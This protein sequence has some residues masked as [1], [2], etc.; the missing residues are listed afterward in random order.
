MKTPEQD[1][2]LSDVLRNESYVAFRAELHQKSLAEFRRQRWVQRRSRFLALAACVPVLLGLY[3]FLTP[4]AVNRSEPQ[5]VVATIRSRPLSKDQIITTARLAGTLVTTI[6]QDLRLT[7]PLATIEV[8]R[9]GIQLESV[10]TISDE[11]LL[12]LFP[13][14]PIALVTRQ[15]GTKMLVFLDGL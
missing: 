4:R 2:L 10:A 1:R 7:L 12:D 3:L 9:T 11:Q 8:V 13:G 14:R 6:P 5:A 15:S